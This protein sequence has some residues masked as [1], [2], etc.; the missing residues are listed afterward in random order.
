MGGFIKR[1]QFGHFGEKLVIND[2]KNYYLWRKVI[3]D[4][5]LT[6]DDQAYYIL[7][8]QTISSDWDFLNEIR[9]SLK[10]LP[11]FPDIIHVKGH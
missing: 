1:Q 6:Y 9:L 8:S 3:W 5:F 10:E 4:P 11:R 7:P 2:Q